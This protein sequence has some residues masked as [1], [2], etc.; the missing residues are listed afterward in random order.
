MPAFMCVS[1]PLPDGFPGVKVREGNPLTLPSSSDH[2]NADAGTTGNIARFRRNSK[3]AIPKC[4]MGFNAIRVYTS[5]YVH[6]HMH[7][8]H[9]L[10]GDSDIL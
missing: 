2:V 6:T 7:M 9:S 5:I 8:Q 10:R 1:I 4:S 3:E